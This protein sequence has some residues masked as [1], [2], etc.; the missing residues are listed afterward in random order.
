M[1]ES[2]TVKATPIGVAFFLELRA[3]LSLEDVPFLTWHEQRDGKEPDWRLILVISD[4][5][6]DQGDPK[7]AN[8]LRWLYRWDHWPQHLNSSNL[9]NW[10]CPNL[11]PGGENFYYCRYCAKNSSNSTSPF[12]AT[13]RRSI[14]PFT[15]YDFFKPAA[16]GQRYSEMPIATITAAIAFFAKILPSPNFNPEPAE[17][18]R[19]ILPRKVEDLI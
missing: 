15:F 11:L 4:Y 3:V 7:T 8:T 19:D 17:V 14:L 9:Y 18:F 1:T 16:R 13:W 12:T 10:Y 5:L 6:E 2:E